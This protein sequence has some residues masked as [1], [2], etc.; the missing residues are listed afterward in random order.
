M[1]R[2]TF[3]RHIKMQPVFRRHS[4]GDAL[5]MANVNVIEAVIKICTYLYFI[6]YNDIFF[7][8]L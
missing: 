2:E 4:D 5:E 3:S 7:E 1:N 8:Y 6:Q